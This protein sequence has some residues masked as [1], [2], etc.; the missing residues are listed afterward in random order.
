MR[1]SLPDSRSKGRS[2]SWFLAYNTI[3]RPWLHWRTLSP[4]IIYS[5]VELPISLQRLRMLELAGSQNNMLNPSRPHTH[6]KSIFLQFSL[7]MLHTS[8]TNKAA[9]T[10]RETTTN[11]GKL[12]QVLYFADLDLA[13]IVGVCCM[14]VLVR[15]QYHSSI[16]EFT[17]IGTFESQVVSPTKS[18]VFRY[19]YFQDATRYSVV[20][21]Q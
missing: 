12:N 17:T 3:A 1:E 5:V 16:R 13:P 6:E 9:T 8:C 2:H 14:N 20:Q 18:I 11:T 21:Y 19:C 7:Q 15:S 4:H 10:G